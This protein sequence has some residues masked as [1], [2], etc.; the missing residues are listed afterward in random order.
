MIFAGT[1]VLSATDLEAATK[2][3]DELRNEKGKVSYN[4]VFV[5]NGISGYPMITVIGVTDDG[6]HPQKFVDDMIVLAKKH[7][8]LCLVDFHLA[9]PAQMMKIKS[10]RR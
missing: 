1:L 2:F 3:A 9:M 5:G 4:S 10:H 7:L 8:P 6:A